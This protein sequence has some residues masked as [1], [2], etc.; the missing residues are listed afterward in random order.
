MGDPL[1]STVVKWWFRLLVAGSVSAFLGVI[2]FIQFGVSAG[3]MPQAT[4]VYAGVIGV[5]MVLVLAWV[6]GKVN[7]APE[8]LEDFLRRIGLFKDR[9]P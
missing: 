2:V 1:I 9:A 3:T 4:Y 6:R 8:M 5:L 7:K